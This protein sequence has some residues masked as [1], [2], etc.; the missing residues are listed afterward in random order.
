MAVASQPD[1]EWLR[2]YRREVPVDVLTAVIDGEVTFAELGGAAVG[3]AAVTMAPDGMRWVGLS[4]VHVVEGPGVA[5]W[6]ANCV[7]PCWRGVAN[8]VP[9]APMCRCSPT[10]LQ[11]ESCMSRWA[12]PFTTARGMSTPVAYSSCGWPRGT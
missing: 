10:T 9:R 11:Q 4:A 7:L 2:L 12:S 8:A 6:H 5:A 3:R 1:D